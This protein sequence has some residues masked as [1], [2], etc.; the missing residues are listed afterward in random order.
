[1]QID[2][3]DEQLAKDSASIELRCDP[4]SNVNVESEEQPKKHFWP[5]IS[6][7]AGMQIERRDVHKENALGLIT[8][9]CDTGR[10]VTSERE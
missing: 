4:D 5:R 6:T 7:D 3:S 1:M 10:N 2:F 9:K 8:F